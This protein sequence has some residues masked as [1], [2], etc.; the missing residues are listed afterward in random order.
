MNFSTTGSVL[1]GKAEH[2]T[3]I[4]HERLWNAC[5]T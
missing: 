2:I 1:S 3:A 4:Q 5:I